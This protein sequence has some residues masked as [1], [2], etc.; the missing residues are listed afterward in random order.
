LVRFVR[1]DEQE[2]RGL[3]VADLLR[4]TVGPLLVEHLEPVLLPLAQRER[5]VVRPEPLAPAPLLERVLRRG[6]DRREHA[7]R[8]VPAGDEPLVGGRAAARR[9]VAPAVAL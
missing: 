7:A 6:R 2:V 8:G 9:A 3:V 4:E 1:R 5:E